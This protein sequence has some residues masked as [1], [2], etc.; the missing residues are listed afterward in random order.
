[1][2]KLF[3]VL[4]LLSVFCVPSY[5]AVPD[6]N[7]VILFTNDVHCGVDENIG[8]AG[9]E[10]YK[11]EQEK[12]TPYVTLVDAG[13]W[14]QG[15][16]IGSISQGRYILEIMNAMNY[17]FAV[18]GNHE[19]DYGW[20]Q[21]ESY[22]RNLKC[23]LYA[24]NLRDIR[25][26]EL[27]LNPYKIF[28]Y[29][30]VKVAFVG[31]ATPETIVKST[32][33]TFMDN[34][35]KFIYDFDGETT[36]QKLI[37]TIQKTV[38]HARSNGA[39]Y[40]FVVGHLGEYEDVTEVWSAPFIAQRTR[41]IDAFI[42]GHSHEVTTG[43]HFMNAESKD[44]VIVQTG[45]RI[46]NIGQVTITTN[47]EIKTE[48]INKVD[49]KDEKITALIN[50]IKARFEDTLKQHLSYTSFDLRAL[51]D[52]GEWIL[53]NAETNL[54]NLITDAMMYS[55]HDTGT[56]NADVALFNAGG[57]RDNIMT[58]EI[59]FS[60][61]LSVLPFNNTV[62]VCEVLG[63]VLLDE[64]E[65]GCRLLPFRSGGFLH[66]SGMTFTADSTIPSPVVLDNTNTLVEIKDEPRRVKDVKVNGEAL[67]PDKIYKVVSINYVLREKGDGH[68]FSGAKLIEPDYASASD[69]FAR[70]IKTFER[71]PEE[72][73]TSQNRI[74]IIK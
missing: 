50:D 13:D 39:D 48:L 3:A 56:K 74:T 32:P 44:V 28:N 72:Y 66:V 62:C 14:A 21:F 24:C 18:P 42:D 25:T 6:N 69:S 34:D 7:I 47:G 57:M 26:G 16:N 58:G 19:F 35:G 33:S 46:H 30:D 40:V 4:M 43:L 12:I 2:K 49:G 27:I 10:F 54:C 65:V 67:D 31:A 63:Q 11:H 52:D 53:R 61:A 45:T 68:V 55:V 38:D 60:D 51:D 22:M 36:G 59:K 64:L 37:S 8:Y 70:Y 29:G 20:G 1:M 15:G 41:N 71:L 9:V 5:A 23:G 73:R 17:Q